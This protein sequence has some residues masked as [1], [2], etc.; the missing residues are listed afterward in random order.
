MGCTIALKTADVQS[1]IARFPD[2]ISQI[3]YIVEEMT[4]RVILSPSGLTR[5]VE[6]LEREK[7]VERQVDAEDARAFHAVLTDARLE[8]LDKART[9]HNAVVRALFLDR[10]TPSE[11]RRL[12]AAWSK[13]PGD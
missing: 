4:V 12:G 2:L 9:T 13:V 7:L 11:Q 8:R 6:R 3:C 1:N 5:M 10:L